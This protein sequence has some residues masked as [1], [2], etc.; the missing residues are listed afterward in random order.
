MP[1]KGDIYSANVFYQKTSGPSK[2][3][4]VLIINDNSIGGYTIVEITSISPKDPPG[5]YDKFKEEIKKWSKYGLHEKSYVKCRNIHN[6]KGV[7]FIKYIGTVD[8]DEFEHIVNK[9][10][11]ANQS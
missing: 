4:P 10:V 3:R 6:I 1:N 2:A 8:S 11:E 9:I 5:Y 7:R